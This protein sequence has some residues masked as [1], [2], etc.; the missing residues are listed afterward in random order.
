MI[1]GWDKVFLHVGTDVVVSLKQVIAILDLRTAGSPEQARNMVATLGRK[2]R[3]IDIAN[4]DPKS[5]VLTDTEAYLSPISS[6]TLKKRSDFVP[7]QGRLG[8]PL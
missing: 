3:V 1:G 5:L 4:G 7:D 6:L 2:K 8:D